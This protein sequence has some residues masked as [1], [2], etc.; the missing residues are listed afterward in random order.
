VE[1]LASSLDWRG[2][3]EGA[4]LF[5]P[6]KLNYP[7][8]RLLLVEIHEAPQGEIAPPKRPFGPLDRPLDGTQVPPD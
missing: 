4:R 7:L 6:I 2:P 5:F 3:K 8:E 1:S